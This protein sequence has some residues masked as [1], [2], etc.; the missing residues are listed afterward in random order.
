MYVRTSFRGAKTC[1]IGNKGV[2]LAI[3]TRFGKDMT[4]KLRKT[5]AKTHISKGSKYFHT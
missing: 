1:K 2:F 3:L 4:D 5:H